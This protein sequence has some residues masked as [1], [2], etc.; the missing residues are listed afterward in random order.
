ES[1]DVA[2]DAEIVSHHVQPLLCTDRL[3]R[4]LRPQAPLVPLEAPLGAHYLGEVHALQP[5]EF[6]CCLHS[7]VLIDLLAVHDA[8]GLCPLL[9]QQARELARVDSG[10]RHEAATLEK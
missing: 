4:A 6:A 7:S 2:L 3:A 5:R 10:D 9:A 8:A 1:E